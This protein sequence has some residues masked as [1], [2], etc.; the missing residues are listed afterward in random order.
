MQKESREA[1][2]LGVRF[3]NLLQYLSPWHYCQ[4]S[5]LV[6]FIV[7]LAIGICLW[8]NSSWLHA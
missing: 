2:I 7:S 6:H 8:G 1:G 4:Y 3:I 5:C